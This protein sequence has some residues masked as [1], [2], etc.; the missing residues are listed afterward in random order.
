MP[1]ESPLSR[2]NN[3]QLVSLTDGEQT[4]LGMFD[5]NGAGF[6]LKENGFDIQR[7]IQMLLDIAEN[8]E[9]DGDRLC[10]IRMLDSKIERIAEV[11]GL[12]VKAKAEVVV[13]GRDGTMVTETRSCTRLLSTLREN[14]NAHAE[15]SPFAGRGLDPIET[16]ISAGDAGQSDCSD[17]PDG[18]DE[19][20]ENGSPGT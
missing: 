19:L 12:M 10:A 15:S 3:G 13:R 2:K 11:N 8:A 7:Q 9:K 14:P 18:L 5:A 6:V 20:R 1:P 16:I 4:I 17:E